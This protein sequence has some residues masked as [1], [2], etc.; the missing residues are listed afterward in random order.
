MKKTTPH[1]ILMADESPY[2]EALRCLVKDQIKGFV[3]VESPSEI[4]KATLPTN[5]DLFMR[6]YD[7]DLKTWSA[8][9]VKKHGNNRK[10]VKRKKAKN[11]R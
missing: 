11:R 7:N 9:H 1:I 3:F 6:P 8:N 2:I 5:G 10:K 4:P